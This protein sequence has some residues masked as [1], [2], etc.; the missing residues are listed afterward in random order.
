MFGACC[1]PISD[2]RLSKWGSGD[3]NLT[4]SMPSTVS[5]CDCGPL[6][7][8]WSPAFAPDRDFARGSV[9]SSLVIS[10]I[11]KL[12][13]SLQRLRPSRAGTP[14]ASGPVRSAQPVHLDLA[15][16]ANMERTHLILKRSM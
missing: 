6:S 1:G 7:R 16:A 4:S 8:D 5:L 13:F 14:Y 11:V 10:A 3:S 15:L 2:S 9:S 12:A